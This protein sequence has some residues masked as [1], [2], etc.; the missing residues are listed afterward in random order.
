MD[1]AL[2]LFEKYAWDT[3]DKSKKDTVRYMSAPGQATS[4]MIGQLAIWTLRNKTEDALK[5]AGVFFDIKEFH[6][7]IL[8]QVSQL[9]W[10]INAQHFSSLYHLFEIANIWLWRSRFMSQ[11]KLF[12]ECIYTF[13]YLYDIVTGEEPI[14][15]NSLQFHTN[16]SF[17]YSAW[18]FS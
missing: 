10:S 2:S 11:K 13:Q 3:T 17:A 16:T 5:K 6:Y 1:E 4:Y 9:V 12:D 7:Q 14:C 15:W 8:S 18:W